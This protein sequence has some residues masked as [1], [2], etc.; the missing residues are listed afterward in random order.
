MSEAPE[1]QSIDPNASGASI[2]SE[3]NKIYNLLF[4]ELPFRVA[5]RPQG[6]IRLARG[7]L[8][9]LLHGQRF[10]GFS[11]RAEVAEAKFV[12]RSISAAGPKSTIRSDVTCFARF[13]PCSTSRKRIAVVSQ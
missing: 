3:A 5:L 13:W 2:F 9:R 4:D 1:L 10:G 6:A 11:C 12:S 8:N 7:R